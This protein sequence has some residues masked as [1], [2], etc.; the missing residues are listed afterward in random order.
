MQDGTPNGWVGNIIL[1]WI[2]GLVGHFAF[3]LLGL[4]SWGTIGEIVVSVIGACLVIWLVRKF[5]LG[6]W[7]DK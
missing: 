5:N 6:R 2:G 1:G 7:F 3:G 4:K